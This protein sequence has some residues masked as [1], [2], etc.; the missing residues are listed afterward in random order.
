MDLGTSE[1]KKSSPPALYR[2]SRDQYQAHFH[3]LI[4]SI[5]GVIHIAGKLMESIV[6]RQALLYAHLGV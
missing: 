3:L 5:L 4:L 2:C 6:I 1:T